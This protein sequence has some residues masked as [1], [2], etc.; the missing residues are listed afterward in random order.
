MLFTTWLFHDADKSA[1]EI[2]GAVDASVRQLQE[3][4]LDSDALARAR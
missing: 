4:P 1:D 3:A 2:L